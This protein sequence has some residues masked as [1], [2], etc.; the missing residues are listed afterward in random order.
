M[1]TGQ[2]NAF[3]Q[4]NRLTFTRLFHFGITRTRPDAAAD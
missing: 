1:V 3:V 2:D 4:H